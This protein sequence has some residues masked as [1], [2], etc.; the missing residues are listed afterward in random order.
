MRAV[1]K[2]VAVLT[3]LLIFAAAIIG[4]TTGL[5]TSGSPTNPSQNPIEPRVSLTEPLIKDISADLGWQNTGV[6]LRSGE[7]INILYV[8]GEIRDAESIIRG[9]AGAGWTCGEG[10]CCEPMTNVPRDA[11]IGRVGDHLFL[12]GDKNAI[13][14]TTNGELQLRINDCDAGLFDNSG[15]LKVKI[16][17]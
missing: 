6:T 5:K 12:I 14:V 15:S 8:S 7:R 2:T 10:T 11:L 17:H 1:V 9:P 13:T 3:V 16:L 4:L